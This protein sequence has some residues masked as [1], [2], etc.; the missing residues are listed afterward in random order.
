[1]RTI[2]LPTRRTGQSAPVT[3]VAFG[4]EGRRLAS[5]SYDGTVLIW[6]MTDP[7]QPRQ[8]VRFR[9]RRLVNSSA[10]NPV[11]PELLATA[12]A[13]KTVGVWRVP[14]EGRAELLNVLARHTDDINSVAW[15]PDGRRLIAVSED[16]RATLWD[17]LDGRLFGEVGSH[18]AHCMMVSVSP[19]GLVATVGED[20]MVA[21]S[22]PG[23]DH[24]PVVRHYES[25]VEGC[26]WSH[27]GGT[28]AIARDDGVV[29]LLTSALQPLRAIQVSRSAARSVAWAEDD[30]TFVVGA[31]DGSLCFY[32]A[33]GALLHRVHDPR[34]WPRSVAVARGVAVV[35]SFWSGPHVFDLASAKEISGPSTPTHG[36]NAFASNGRELFVGCDSGRVLAIGL[37]GVATGA[38]RVLDVADGP[39]LS[40]AAHGDILYAGTYAGHIVRHEAG[41]TR[42][43]SQV[44]APVPS[45]CLAG[46]R[47][48]GGTY[49]GEIVALDPR[50]LE[51]VGRRTP[52]AGS[53]KSLAPGSG[54][55]FSAATDR[56][57]AAGSLDDRHTLWQHGNL[58][59]AVAVLD[60]EVAASASRDHTVKVGRL[61]ATPGEVRQVQTLLG[62]DESVKCVA[63]LGS[64]ESPVVLAGSYDFGLYAWNVDWSAGART[65][66]SGT[67]VAEFTQGVSCMLALDATR[68]AVA[69][70]DGRVLIAGLAPDGTVEVHR[71][72][73]VISLMESA[74]CFDDRVTA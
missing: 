6:D 32:E 71:T 57:V 37:D 53:V 10:W 67:T 8:T 58:V 70:W 24:A 74:S 30:N 64:P 18:T 29:E 1:M 39:I 45:L 48:M 2:N 62:P 5:C 14:D 31:Y 38:P 61:G 4:K 69:G 50:S 36:P 7:G 51:I 11:E 63:L 20:G 33:N 52:H 34:I 72:W 55:F 28:L 27:S 41:R 43:S 19:Q 26:A 25:S 21:V 56:T 9:H 16:G 44:G 23:T 15:M 13:D 47:V 59:N 46:G 42:E 49:N 40:L 22:A 3:H 73:D 68:V 17:A 60:G 54:G 35:G 66:T 65:L 12:S